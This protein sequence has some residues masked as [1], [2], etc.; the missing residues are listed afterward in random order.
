[1]AIALDEGTERVG[2]AGFRP[3]ALVSFAML[4]V[5]MN[6][7]IVVVLSPTSAAVSATRPTICRRLSP[8]MPLPTAASSFSEAGRRICW[9]G[10]ACSRP[11]LPCSRSPPS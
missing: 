5:S 4:I 6:Q 11:A 8:R 1:M 10:D 3:L 7:Y 2:R 9:G